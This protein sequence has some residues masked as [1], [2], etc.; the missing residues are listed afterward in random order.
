MYCFHELVIA[1]FHKAWAIEGIRSEHLDHFL[2]VDDLAS[3]FIDTT[4]VE[5]SIIV[6]KC[7]K[8]YFHRV[9]TIVFHCRVCYNTQTCY[10]EIEY[11]SKQIMLCVFQA[12]PIKYMTL[13]GK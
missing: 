9:L 5:S 6:S 8:D 11:N 7:D 4:F 1:N 2:I 10:S 12:N 3:V 13:L